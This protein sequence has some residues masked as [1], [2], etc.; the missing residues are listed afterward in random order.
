[1]HKCMNKCINN[2]YITCCMFDW[3]P[4]K[5]QQGDKFSQITY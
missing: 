3:F 2:L 1:M 4:M 5:G